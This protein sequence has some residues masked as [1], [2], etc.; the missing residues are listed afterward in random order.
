MSFRSRL[1]PLFECRLWW[2]LSVSYNMLKIAF[3]LW[4]VPAG[5]ATKGIRS[6]LESTIADIYRHTTATQTLPAPTCSNRRAS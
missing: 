2:W 4:I 5:G 3:A 1:F 6:T